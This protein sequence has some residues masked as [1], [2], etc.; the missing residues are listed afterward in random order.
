METASS[1]RDTA[2]Q[3]GARPISPGLGP[4]ETAYLNQHFQGTSTGELDLV[5]CIPH[6]CCARH[7]GPDLK[8]G[9]RRKGSEL[10]GLKVLLDVVG[11]EDPERKENQ[12]GILS[13]TIAQRASPPRATVTQDFNE[14]PR[15]FGD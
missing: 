3:W 5:S 8:N 2:Q 14:P 13:L 10:G 15:S 11:E 1:P 6:S 9:E 4:L 7:N 12:A